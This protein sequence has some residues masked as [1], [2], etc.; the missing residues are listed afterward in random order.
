MYPISIIIMA[1]GF[2][3]RMKRNKLLMQ[4][5]GK[6][7]ISYIIDETKNI[8]SSEKI[9]VS[10]YDE[11]LDLAPDDY[12]KVRN[13]FSIKGQSMS[14]RLGVENSDINNSYLFLAGDMPLITSEKIE[15]VIDF[16]RQNRDKIIVPK[17]EE[18]TGM[19]T[20]FPSFFRENLLTLTGDTGGKNIIKNFPEKVS[21][22]YSEDISYIFDI[23]EEK[24]IKKYMTLISP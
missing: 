15:K 2:S 11:I 9:I 10:S 17:V 13:D 1:S 6:K 22:F 20:I 16:H 24:D 5:N 7:L 19:P 21:Y 14:V 18:K 3:R 8:S 23:D 4:V 12:I